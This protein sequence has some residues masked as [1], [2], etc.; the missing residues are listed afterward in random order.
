MQFQT[1]YTAAELQGKEKNVQIAILLNAAGAEA[2]EIHEQFTFAETEDKEDYKVVLK[3]FD[4]YCRPRKNVVYDRHRFWSRNQCEEEPVDKWVKELRVI[5]KD[6]D[7][8]AQEDNMIRDRIVFG[9]HD[10]R[11]QERMLRDGNLDLTKAIELCRAAESSK[12]QM[13]EIGKSPVAISE[14]KNSKESAD[15]TCVACEGSGCLR[16]STPK[17]QSSNVR[18]YNCQRFGHYSRDCPE[19]DGYPKAKRRGRGRGRVRGRSGR[20]RGRSQRN[21]SE[22]ELSTEPSE[23]KYI[24]EFASLSLHSIEVSRACES[25]EPEADV[26][27]QTEVNN[28][29]NDDRFPRDFAKPSSSGSGSSSVSVYPE[30]CISGTPPPSL[31]LHSIEI[32]AMSRKLD[33]RTS[34]RYAKFLF[35]RPT[36]RDVKKVP[37]KIDSGSERNALGLERFRTL[38]PEKVGP[39]GLPPLRP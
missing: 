12:N 16:N 28:K 33:E 13:A 29:T 6:C 23:E 15:N 24:Q 38:Y 22:H 34:K 7:F 10:K 32:N 30:Y 35:H 14:L 17:P 27:F 21:F 3:K 20:N 37:L 1:C 19:G 11:V 2:Q 26:S 8:D 36:K 9:V 25:V 5:A 31:S 39:D 18:C 4:L